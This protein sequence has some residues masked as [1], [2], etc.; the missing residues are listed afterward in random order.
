MS[1]NEDRPEYKTITRTEEWVRTTDA[2][3]TVTDREDPQGETRSNN[4]IPPRRPDPPP[5]ENE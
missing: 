1:E 3:P 2:T 4:P 5:R